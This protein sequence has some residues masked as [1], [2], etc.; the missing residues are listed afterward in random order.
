MGLHRLLLHPIREVGL[1]RNAFGR[2]PVMPELMRLKEL[3]YEHLLKLQTGNSKYWN[4]G[5]G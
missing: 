2:L 1:S 5:I 4:P 3:G